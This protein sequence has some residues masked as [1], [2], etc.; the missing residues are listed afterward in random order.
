MRDATADLNRDKNA[1][2]AM[3]AATWR[4]GSRLVVSWPK[5]PRR[6]R[7]KADKPTDSLGGRVP[8]GASSAPPEATR[9]CAPASPQEAGIPYRKPLTGGIPPSA[10]IVPGAGDAGSRWPGD[11]VAPAET[12]P[13]VA[14]ERDMPPRKKSSCLRPDT[15]ELSRRPKDPGVAACSSGEGTAEAIS[16]ACG[17]SPDSAMQTVPEDSPM[18]LPRTRVDEGVVRDSGPVQRAGVSGRVSA[19]QIRSSPEHYPE[20]SWPSSSTT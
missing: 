3:L 17:T 20:G 19:F 5:R 15:V 2:N 1:S 13:A 12:S 7:S 11:S 16:S 9:A 4:S 10:G 18:R 6:R 14:N 8:P